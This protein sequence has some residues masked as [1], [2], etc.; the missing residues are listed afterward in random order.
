MTDDGGVSTSSVPVLAQV[1]G[2]PLS[3]DAALAAV[4]D[5]QAG[6][7]VAFVGTVRD[8]D[9]GR[10]GVTSLTYSAHPRA[11]E[12]LRG[13][14]ERT[15]ALPGVC[16]VA[17]VHREGELA[18]GDLAVLC[19]VSARHRAEAFAGARALIEELKAQVPIW[20][21]QAFADGEHEWVGL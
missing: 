11:A 13:V 18:V 1:Q 6:A 21:D 7:L 3:I 12:I 19:V 5:R 20:K 17:A 4:R 14:A 8:H 10:D 16:G 9:G 2:E 15:A